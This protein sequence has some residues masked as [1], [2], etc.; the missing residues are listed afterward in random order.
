MQTVPFR[1]TLAGKN[2][3]FMDKVPMPKIQSF[4][5]GTLNT[6]L[7][8][9]RNNETGVDDY[10]ADNGRDVFYCCHVGDQADGVWRLSCI[11]RPAAVL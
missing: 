2:G 11:F 10:Y 1:D 5:K 4:H 6:F 9:R 8:K 3:V 7:L